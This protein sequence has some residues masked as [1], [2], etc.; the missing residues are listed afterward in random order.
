MMLVFSVRVSVAVAH[1]FFG[2]QW[3]TT[4]RRIVSEECGTSPW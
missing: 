3:V 2:G 4:A 1:G